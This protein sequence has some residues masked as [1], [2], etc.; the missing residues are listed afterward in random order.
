MDTVVALWHPSPRIFYLL[1]FLMAV[2]ALNV[3]LRY[4]P[5]TQLVA[6][7]PLKLPWARGGGP[8]PVFPSLYLLPELRPSV[9]CFPSWGSPLPSVLFLYNM[10]IGPCRVGS[11]CPGSLTV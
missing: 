2:V 11:Y 10:H 4:Q 9:L 6:P 7:P 5:E 1:V 3:S 8:N